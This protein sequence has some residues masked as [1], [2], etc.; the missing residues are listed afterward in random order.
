MQD[1]STTFIAYQNIVWV[2][3]GSCQISFLSGDFFMLPVHGMN[4]LN[5][6]YN[7]G[8]AALFKYFI[9]FTSRFSEFLVY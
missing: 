3:H 5:W 4:N 8:I 6:Y 1:N 9:L 7:A 2:H